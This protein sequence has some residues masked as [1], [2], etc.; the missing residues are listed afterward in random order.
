MVLVSI[1]CTEAVLGLRLALVS[2]R[3]GAS[4]LR[5]SKGQLGP[6]AARPVEGKTLGVGAPYGW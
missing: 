2:V 5:R 3:G 4:G 1:G 6:R